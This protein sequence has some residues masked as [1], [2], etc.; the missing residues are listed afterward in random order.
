MYYVGLDVH[1]RQSSFCVLDDNG[2][3]L[4]QFQVKGDWPRMLEAAGQLPRP[5]SL[6][7]EA[8]CGYGYLHERL[9][10]LAS[11]G[12]SGQHGLEQRN[13][14]ACMSEMRIK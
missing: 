3:E 14:V 5:F 4:R 11:W 6:C 10:P 1:A 2:K 13:A 8:S 12:G 7:Y 9:S